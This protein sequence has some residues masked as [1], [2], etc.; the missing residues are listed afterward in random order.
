MSEPVAIVR[1]YLAADPD[2]VATVGADWVFGGEVHP[3]RVDEMPRRAV[4]I[5]D[6]GGLGVIGQAFQRYGDA[7]IDVT[8]WGTT[9]QEAAG[10]AKLVNEALKHRLLGSVETAHGMLWWA[11]AAGGL[12]S[13]RDP[14]TRWS[15][16]MRTW[17]VLAED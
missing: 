3:D 9:P 16:H 6:A 4:V 5:Q 2:I 15:G 11:K 10:T 17:Q 7:R 13:F 8:C 14:D 1:D 12:G